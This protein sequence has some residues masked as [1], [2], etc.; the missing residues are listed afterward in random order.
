MHESVKENILLRSYT[1]SEM[2]TWR[3]RYDQRTLYFVA[4][5]VPPWVV[6][7]SQSGQ[8]VSFMRSQYAT[9]RGNSSAAN[10]EKKYFLC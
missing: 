1:Y 9:K 2:D 10:N 6:H 7:S 3:V 8:Y 4:R 5:V